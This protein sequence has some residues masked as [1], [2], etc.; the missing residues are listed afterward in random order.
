MILDELGL[1]RTHFLSPASGPS[2]LL[3]GQTNV[4]L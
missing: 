2:L 4:T 3:W 1:Q